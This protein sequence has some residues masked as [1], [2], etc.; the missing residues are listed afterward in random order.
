MKKY[1]I[2]F[3]ALRLP[4]EFFVVFF[5]FFMARS[6]R[7]VTDLIPG[8]HLPIK[9]IA[10]GELTNF[11]ILGSILF[12]LIFIFSGLYKIKISNSKVK[13]FFDIAR[14]FFIWF[15]FYVAILYLALWYLYR[16]EIPRLIIF[17]ALLI[18]F[19]AIIFERFLLDLLIKKLIRSW[20]FSKNRVIL[21]LKWENNEV[22][23][24]FKKT[25]YYDILG[26]INFSKIEDV[27]LAYLWDIKELKKLIKNQELD[28]IILINT[29]YSSLDLEEIFEYSRIYWVKY[30][31]LSNSFD[32]IKNNT[33]VSFLG[34]IPITEIKSIW[35]SP[36]WRVIKRFF[37]IIISF[38]SLI[39]LFPFFL[40]ISILIKL[41]DPSWPAIYKNKRVWKNQSF[42][43]LYKF[44]YM[45]REYCIKDSYWVDHKEDE[46]LE[47][48]KQLIK[49]KSTR[50][51][52]LYKIENDPRK[53]RIWAIIE[54]FSI[55]ELPQLFNVLVWNMSL[56]W[57]RPH[58][59]REVKL[60]KEYQKR[61][62]TI[63]PW[64]TGMAQ[65]NWRENNDFDDEVNLDIFYIENRSLLLDFKILVKTIMTVILR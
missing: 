61:V 27:N 31:Y 7:L 58:Q 32:L 39:F 9:T 62:L 22:I 43:N 60:Y 11:A 12:S 55:D 49:E 24:E 59:P 20:V 2:T 50:T 47:Y 6:I 29:D 34:K 35:L 57:P 56:V 41:E 53:T 51:G 33:E 16:V 8:V 17:F 46:A 13:E 10:T 36:W 42:F 25:F 14:S 48:E 21:I 5:A 18:A 64:I 23:D 30:K 63:K 45:K 15:L 38:I 44:R 3:W 26:Y 28:E 1:E 52:P 40:I 19:F 54:R 37:D 65:V 4:L